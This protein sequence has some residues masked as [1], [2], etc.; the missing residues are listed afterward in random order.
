MLSLGLATEGGCVRG[1]LML[2]KQTKMA[3]GG[4][5]EQKGFEKDHRHAAGERSECETSA[6]ESEE[7]HVC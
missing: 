6:L 7:R 5:K 3:N 1:G 4:C 2:R